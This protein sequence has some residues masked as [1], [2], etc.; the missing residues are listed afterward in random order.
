MIFVSFIIPVYNGEKYIE[1]CVEQILK[2]KE[3]SAY[4]I[5]LI[6]DGS[7]DN[8]GVICARLSRKFP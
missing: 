4:E 5:I 2:N 7:T 6:N 8:S 3:R 1:E